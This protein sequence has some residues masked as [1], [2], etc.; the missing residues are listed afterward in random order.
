MTT[1]PLPSKPRRPPTHRPR[2]ALAEAR[3]V[4]RAGLIGTILVHLLLVLFAFWLP[5]NYFLPDTPTVEDEA[6]RSFEIEI[7]ESFA[8]AAESAKPEPPSLK[9]VEVNPAA[10]DNL[11][12]E[13]PNV[14]VQNQQLAQPVPS[15]ETSGDTPK[16]DGKPD[17]ETTALVSGQLDQ[18]KVNPNTEFSPIFTP[19]E[20]EPFIREPSTAQS[21][22]AREVMPLPG[23]EELLANSDGSVG[24][25]ITSYTA[26][27]SETPGPLAEGKPDG[28][29]QGQ[30]YFSDTPRINP[31]RP[32]RRPSLATRAV[33]ARPTMT[34]F[35]AQGAKNEGPLAYDAKWSTYGEYIQRLID[36][37]QVQW[38]RLIIR[39][40]IYPAQGTTVRVT[41]L[42][43]SSGAISKIV[44][45]EGS[46]D[47]IASYLC[48]SAITE[49]APFGEWS[50]DMI[51]VL[52]KE[53]EMSFR[54]FYQ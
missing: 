47:K 26:K 46:D 9:F 24:S 54:F 34:I 38:E 49:R 6:S 45:V 22:S 40:P 25:T 39:S 37:V 23:A 30:G 28:Q 42:I 18:E 53:Q 15:P 31:M 48:V 2:R 10:P 5:K 13:T 50:E 17:N 20:P 29:A 52:G 35:S 3:P 27:P 12:D 51:A 36:A 8:N 19:P 16:V 7:A 14:G 21:P 11:P 43:N 44:K 1:A 4:W 32:Q 33:N 41:F